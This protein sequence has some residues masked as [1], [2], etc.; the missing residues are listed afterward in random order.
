V[1]PIN[2]LPH[3]ETRRKEQRKRFAT[4]AA[5]TVVLGSIIVFVGHTHYASRIEEQTGRN[6]FLEGEIASLDRQIAEISKLKEQTKALLGRKKVVESLQSNRSE[7]VRLLDQL[8]RQIPD[9]VYLKAVKQQGPTV[10]VSGYASSSARVSTLMRNLDASPWLE[11]PALVEIKS[12]QVNNQ[13]QN[14][15][16]LNVRLS[17]EAPV[18]SK[19]A[20]TGEIPGKG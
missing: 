5:L 7:T 8:I 20:A 13:P 18:P 19:S 16:N 6:Q 10:N 1:I 14:E 12:V 2:L 9:G 15:F 11:E 17:R 3:R 4:M